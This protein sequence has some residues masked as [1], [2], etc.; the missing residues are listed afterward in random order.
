MKHISESLGRYE[1]MTAQIELEKPFPIT[2]VA[3][4][5]LLN[6]LT[7]EQVMAIPDDKMQLLAKKMADAY[8]EGAFWDDLETLAG[9]ILGINLN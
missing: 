8:V 9:D 3:R 2:S 4:A 7:L 1:K 6:I 5:D